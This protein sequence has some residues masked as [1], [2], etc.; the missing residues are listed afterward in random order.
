MAVK[1]LFSK[2]V[3]AVVVSQ[4]CV[5]VWGA[6]KAIAIFGIPIGS[7]RSEADSEL[8]AQKMYP[9]PS[10]GYLIYAERGTL[11][12][13]HWGPM[14]KLDANDR[15]CEVVGTELRVGDDCLKPGAKESDVIKL[16][17]EPSGSYE[18]KGA[19]YPSRCLVYES[20][21]L[22]VQLIPGEAESVARSFRTATDRKLL[23]NG[24]PV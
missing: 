22:M 18:P 7:S 2:V 15:V 10:D 3:S 9:V 17:G 21:G 6:P 1:K 13:S 12:E 11:V 24:S 16:L 20:Q 19:P 23:Y 14:V 5:A 4:L 8:A